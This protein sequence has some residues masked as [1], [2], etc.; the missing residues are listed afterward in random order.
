[1]ADVSTAFCTFMPQAVQSESVDI[2]GQYGTQIGMV[3]IIG[4]AI[5]LIFARFSKK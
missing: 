2:G 3:M 4:F 5:N 1:M